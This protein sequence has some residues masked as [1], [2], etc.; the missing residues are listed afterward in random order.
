MAST[1]YEYAYSAFPNDKVAPDRLAQEITASVLIVPSLD[2]AS[3]GVVA[4]DTDQICTIWFLAALSTEEQ[5]ALAAIVAAHSGEPLTSPQ[6]V[7]IPNARYD[8]DKKQVVVITPAPRGSFTWYTSHG[9]Q[10]DPSLVRGGGQ[11]M[12]IHFDAQE[13]GTKEVE[14]QFAEGVYVHDGEINWRDPTDFNAGDHFDVF[15][16]FAATA[17]VANP[18]A[19]NCNL[20][21]LGPGMNMIVPAAGD[22][23]HDVDLATACPVP[24]SAGP[25]VVSEKTDVITVGEASGE[26]VMQCALFDFQVPNFYLLRAMSMLSNRGVWE[27]DAY[28]VEWISNKWKL[29]MSVTKTNQVANAVDIAAIVMLFRWNASID[30]P[31]DP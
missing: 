27:I 3:G 28:L 11:E 31:R 18:G 2:M 23:S 7:T 16:K 15:I 1:S 25:Y 12:S 20:Y 8:T 6:E 30:Q 5:A 14:V 4:D 19:G 22:G 21:P 29:C 17:V 13:T 9:D 10:T 24:S 26:F